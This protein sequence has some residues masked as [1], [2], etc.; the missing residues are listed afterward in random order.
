M[1][2]LLS[3]IVAGL[4]FT[5]ALPVLQAADPAQKVAVVHFSK[6]TP[7]LGDVAGWEGEKAQGQ[8][9]DAAG[10]KLTT[11]ERN[12]RKGE[13]TV[14][15]HI[16]DYSESAPMLQA[17]TAT[18]AFTSETAEGYQKAVT[19]DGAKGMEQFENAG[20]KG[21]VI[22]LVAGRYLLQVETHGVPSNELSAW[23]KRIDL[24]KL[25]ELK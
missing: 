12:Y 6:L 11:A 7:F 19:I 20:S 23:V 13:A 22:L 14:K 25:A 2:I 16:M 9:V 1:R 21:S 10:F 4:V 18:W 15:M 5:A 17:I 24:K 8:T 3:S